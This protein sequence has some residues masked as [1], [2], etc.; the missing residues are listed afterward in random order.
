MRCCPKHQGL[1]NDDEKCSHPHHQNRCADKT[2]FEMVVDNLA[3][4]WGVGVQLGQI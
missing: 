2:L 1:V 3:L 4:L